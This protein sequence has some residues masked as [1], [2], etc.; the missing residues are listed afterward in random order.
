MNYNLKMD[1]KKLNRAFVYPIKGKESTVDYVCIP[2][3]EFFVGK[4]DKDG[5]TPLYLN[6]EVK[7]RKEVGSFGDTHFVKQQ[8]EK[9]SYNA[10]SEEKKKAIP[11]IGSFAP[12]KFGNNTETTKPK[13]KEVNGVVDDTIPF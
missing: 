13:A 7:E 10:L 4:A 11:I 6:L 1:I 2:V 3:S 9:E 8:L 5:H 12:S